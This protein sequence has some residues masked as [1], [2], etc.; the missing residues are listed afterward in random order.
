[1]IAL[2]LL[3]LVA[4]RSSFFVHGFAIETLLRIEEFSD[5]QGKILLY[6]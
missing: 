3:H 1:M 6:K 2:L 5:F 4:T